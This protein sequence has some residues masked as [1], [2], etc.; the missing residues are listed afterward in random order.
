MRLLLDTQAWI[1]MLASPN[2]LSTS[3]R[4]LL[5]T[6]DSEIIL[7][8]ASV[9]EMAIKHSIGKLTLPEAPETY[10][11]RLIEESGT[12]ALPIYHRHAALVATLPRHHNDPFDRLLIAQAMVES[13]PIMTADRA[14][15]AYD[16][17]LLEA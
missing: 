11:Q 14:F 8:A 13:I 4:A 9:W 1:W 2:R 15:S 6:P 5:T 16:V 3:S 17:E 10:I 7:S 12:T